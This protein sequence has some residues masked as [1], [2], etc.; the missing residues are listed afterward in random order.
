MKFAP[1]DF[2]RIRTYALAERSNKVAISDFAGVPARG[3][4]LARFLGKTAPFPG[5][6][7]F[8]EDRGRDRAGRPR[9]A[10]R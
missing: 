3:G 6:E 4:T 2:S 7:R 8:P 9:R 5:R 10:A 1:L